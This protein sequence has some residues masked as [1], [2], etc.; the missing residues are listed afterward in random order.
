MT[1]TTTA[2]AVCAACETPL[3]GRWCHACGQDSRARPVPL[4]AL[5]VEVATSYSPVDGKLART[6]AVLVVRPGRL[7]EAYRSGAGS[8]YVTPLKLFVASTALFLSV[9]NFSDT[10]L[11]QYVWKVDRGGQAGPALYDPVSMEVKVQGATDGE[12][13]L[14]PKIEP[15]IDPEVTAAIQAAARAASDEPTRASMRYELVL[16]A[17]QADW[18]AR[19][20]GWLPNVLWLLMP[21]Y[22]VFLIPFFGRRRLFLEHVIFA[23]WAHAV[24]FLLA[25]GLAGINAAGANLSAAWLVVPYLAY[26]TIAAARY[27]AVAPVQAFWRGIV[28]LSLYV[29]LALMPAAV[30]ILATVTDWPALIAWIEAV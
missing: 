19:L 20:S 1:E 21:V 10:T 18:A 28:H 9:L 7:L 30:A 5:V 23:M 15:A 3:T 25:M 17:E 6:L 4:R 24:G 14:Q 8:L 16:N 26:F 27:Y 2:G 12:R 22:A 29:V 13:W 11:V